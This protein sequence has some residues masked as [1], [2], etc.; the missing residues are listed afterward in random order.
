MSEFTKLKLLCTFSKVPFNF[1]KLLF[2][3]DCNYGVRHIQMLCMTLNLIALFIA[4]S[5]L[6]VAILAM[7]DMKRRNDP[8][9]TVYEWDKQT[10]AVILS[11]FFWGYIVMQ[12]PGGLLAK[13]Y[14]GKPV[15]LFALL[16]IAVICVILPSLV[17]FGGWQIVCACRVLMG[18][19]QAC[20]M[21]STHTLLGKW[22]PVH[23]I[24]SYSGIVYGGIQ[25]GIMIAMSLSGVLAETKMGWKLI[26]YVI[27]G[28]KKNIEAGLNVASGKDLKT[29]W[30]QI[31]TIKGFWALLFTHIGAVI[32]FTMFF[33]DMPTYL[34]KG[35]QI[36]LKSSALLSALP[37]VGMLVGGVASTN[38]L[39]KIFL[40]GYLS[41]IACRKL[42]NSIAFIGMAVG[43]IILCFIGPEN[44]TTAMIALIIALTSSG[45]WS[46]GY[47][48][49][50]LDLSPNYGG[51]MLSIS[52]C[53]GNVGSVITPI[54]TSI[55]LRNDPADISRWRIL[56]L[57]TAGLSILANTAFLLFASTE[58]QEWD[59]PDYLE[60]RKADP[61]EL[62][63]AL[64]GGENAEDFRNRKGTFS[65]NVQVVGD[66][67]LCIRNIVARWP[68]SAHDSHIFNSSN[69]K[70]RLESSEFDYFWLLG[71]SGYALR[72]YLLTTFND[73]QTHAEKYYNESH[74]RTKMQYKDY[75]D[76][77]N[78]D[79]Q[80]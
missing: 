6:G 4:R 61:E 66:A 43:L 13:R 15:V 50:Y 72:P 35:L 70:C 42:F 44:R 23:E 38:L 47:F 37:Y 5:S 78:V 22:L 32:T 3:L 19:T 14:G 59:D 63:P 39:E 17:R 7:T 68:G 31:F 79:F 34:E 51:F 2:I 73:P 76:Y 26:F 25:I 46:V 54:F 11:S 75:L 10:Q 16:S 9:I 33:I 41:L 36:S 80:L 77:G 57:I 71:N 28:R 74:I 24:T 55:I 27:S 40:K 18:M 8:D 53:I 45:F 12:I 52:N 21:S 56:F 60:K 65:I 30:K 49:N 58:R 69:L 29:P 48:M 20:L 1:L 62:K 64:K 67:N